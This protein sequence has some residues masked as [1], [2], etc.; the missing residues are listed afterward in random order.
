MT[1]ATLARKLGMSHIPK[2]ISNLRATKLMSWPDFIKLG[3]AKRPLS[4]APSVNLPA[5]TRSSL[6]CRRIFLQDRSSFLGSFIEGLPWTD[7]AF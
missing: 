5:V 7:E 6:E 3:L 2:V 1:L 4:Q